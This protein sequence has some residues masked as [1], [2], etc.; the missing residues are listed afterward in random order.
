MEEE[1]GLVKAEQENAIVCM[2]TVSGF[3]ALMK[4]ASL[5]AG[6]D[7]IPLAFQKKPSNVLIACNMA[8]R[9]HADPLSIMQNLQVIHGNPTFSAKFLIGTFNTCGRFSSIKYEFFGE[10]GSDEWG[11]RACSTE[12]STKEKIVG[13][14]VTISM[15]KKEGWYSKK[16]KHGNECSKW[17]TMPQ[18]MLQYRAATF[19]IRTTAP[20]ISLGLTT[21]EVIDLKPAEDGT[22]AVQAEAN[23]VNRKL[24]EAPI[25]HVDMQAPKQKVKTPEPVASN[26]APFAL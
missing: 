26:A 5:L 10:K 16:D 1:K 11:C 22:Y 21:E 4:Q 23:V 20:E 6:S 12:Y 18:L 7:I 3:N 15:A 25:H 19:L 24:N 13:P 2:D 17:Q 9:M 14:D 8:N